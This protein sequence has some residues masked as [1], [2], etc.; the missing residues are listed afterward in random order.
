MAS[1]LMHVLTIL[2][3]SVSQVPPLIGA[4]L[5][6]K[7][8]S[9]NKYGRLF[10]YYIFQTHN[11]PFLYGMALV[12]GNVAGFTKKT[13]VSAIM[14]VAY[15]AGQMAGPQVFRSDEAPLYPTAFISNFVCFALI[16]ATIWLFQAY[17]MWQNW[18]RDRLVTLEGYNPVDED[19]NEGF[20][21]RTDWEQKKTFRY[22][23]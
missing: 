3:L 21:D 8:P 5:L 14:F 15:C 19:I 23:Y 12:S 20:H 7:L 1:L 13:T 6:Y 9:H 4:V 11:V 2:A 18:R 10:S 22:V 16:I 17:L